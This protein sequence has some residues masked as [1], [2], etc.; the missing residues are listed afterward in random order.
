MLSFLRP[1]IKT[2]LWTI[3]LAFL[4]FGNKQTNPFISL[5]DQPY[6]SAKEILL[7]Y[8]FIY[9]TSIV[10]AIILGL[11][12][13]YKKEYILRRGNNWQKFRYRL[14]ASGDS[15]IDNL[16][17]NISLGIISV[18]VAIKLGDLEYHTIGMIGLFMLLISTI[19]YNFNFPK[20]NNYLKIEFVEERVFYTDITY[21]P[22]DR[23]EL[24]ESIHKIKDNLEY[25][26]WIEE[27]SSILS[28]ESTFIFKQS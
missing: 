18:L 7:I 14:M 20:R 1:T 24:N 23:L 22:E 26:N 17:K 4:I 27:K 13:F 25:Y 5:K 6:E 12:P 9:I 21:H 10:F 19:F 3:L 15:N 2:N 28:Q 8:G 16:I 11:I